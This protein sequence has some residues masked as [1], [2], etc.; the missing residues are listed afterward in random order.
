MIVNSPAPRAARP[1][2][3]F[4][5]VE[6]LV[7]IAII[8]ILVALLLPAIQSAR[9]AARRIQCGNNLKNIGLA[10]QNYHD[11]NKQFPEAGLMPRFFLQKDGS[12]QVTS[13]PIVSQNS[14][15]FANWVILTL[16]FLEQ[17]PLYD[18]F[19]AEGRVTGFQDADSPSQ[20]AGI[21]QINR[22]NLEPL[23]ATNLSVMICPS[24]PASQ[25]PFSNTGPDAGEW[26]R[27]NYGINGGLGFIWNFQEVW[28]D[29]NTIMPQFCKKGIATYNNGANL[30]EIE[31]GSSNTIAVAEMRAGLSPIDRRGVWAMGMVGASIHTEHG[32]NFNF[33]I[34]SCGGG[35]DDMVG[36]SAVIAEVG[37]Q[38]LLAD[39]MYPD[40]SFE[41]SASS[42]VRSLHPGGAFAVMADGS[43]H[44]LSDFIETGAAAAGLDCQDQQQ[45]GVWQRLNGSTDGGLVQ[46]VFN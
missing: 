45:L 22:A 34:N 3:G 18:A 23:R 28:D 6:L 46:G 39:C 44:F 30:R 33:G 25:E 16:P 5:L 27:G 8:G 11:T 32:A 21:L 19:A 41:E 17:Q 7:V 12:G 10:L 26:A 35:E 15:L 1:R 29:S 37:E 40:P 43:V 31:D 9:E 20:L 42:T 13:S 36:A 38:T 2:H 14:R 4:T 24:D